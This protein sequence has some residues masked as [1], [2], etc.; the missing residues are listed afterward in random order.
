VRMFGMVF[1][2]VVVSGIILYVLAD[3]S[4]NIDHILKNKVPTGIIVE[5]YKYMALQIF[6]DISP[7]M[8]LVTTLVTFSL[9]SRTN[10][11]TACKALGMSLYRISLPAVLTAL[12]ISVFCAFLESEILPASNERVA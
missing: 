4:E 7:V 2:M 1:S 6:Y 10:E 11:I 9:L 3:L 5:L 12:L 8:V